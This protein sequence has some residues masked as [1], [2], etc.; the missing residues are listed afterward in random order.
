MDAARAVAKVE[1]WVRAVHSSGGMRVDPDGVRRV[2]EGWSVP[3]NTVAYLDGGDA[4]KQVYPPPRLVV[5]EPDGQ[6][7]VPAPRPDGV[8]VPARLPGEGHWAEIV[9]PEFTA[10]GLGYLG[11]PDMAVAGWQWVEADGTRTARDRVNPGYRTGPVRMGHPRP[12]NALEWM[13]VFA[14]VAWFDDRRL[15]T[16]L[17]QTEVLV[18]LDG[19]GRGPALDRYPVYSSPRYLPPD[20]TRWRRVDLA[21]LVGGFAEQPVLSIFGPGT[22]RR[23]PAADVAA[24]LQEFPR[25][26]PPVDVTETRFEVGPELADFA[27][28]TAARVGLAEPVPAP[29]HEARYA[30]LNGFELTDDEV[31]RTVV[32]RTWT[33]LVRDTGDA[34]RLPGDWAA[35]GLQPAYADDGTPVPVVDVHGKYCPDA[36]KGFRYGYRQVTGAF[37]GFALGEALGAAVDDAGLDEIRARYGPD[38]VQDLVAAYDAPGRIGPLTQRLLFLTEGVI[39]AHRAES[40][41]DIAAGGL[42]RWLHTQGDTVDRPVDGW[43]VHVPGLYADRFPDPDD[44]EAV[45]ALAEG[46]PGSGVGASALLAA[47]PAALT[48]GGPGTGL[49]GGAAEAARLLAGLT[50]GSDPAATVYLTHLFQQVLRADEPLPLWIAGRDVRV[51]GVDVA[52]ALPDYAKFGLLDA[53][54]PADMGAGRDAGTVLRQALSAVAGHE[55]HPE[56]ALLRAVNHSGRSALTG[57]IAGA[58]LGARVGVPGLPARWLEQLDLRYVVENLATDAY[59]HFNRSSPLGLGRWDTRYP[60]T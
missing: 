35:H 51:G 46:R 42:V 49:P 21:T 19:G 34:S 14:A 41:A 13:L 30:R 54:R 43:L 3:Y 58:L 18:P 36:P 48:E 59:R 45:R 33:R 2:P 6:L 29:V 55:H 31:R 60:R 28:D 53:P 16:G 22:L 56:A 5:R 38:G 17:T 8:S 52:D 47:L 24:A 32:G 11:V 4:G 26:A 27:R 25:V 20:T 39:R 50:H 1:E 10:S 7:R 40:F 57:A 15:V 9:D 12:V 37:L 23:V 44:L